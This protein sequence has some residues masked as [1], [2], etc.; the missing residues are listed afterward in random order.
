MNSEAQAMSASRPWKSDFEPLDGV[1]D[2]RP[3][4]HDATY[5]S[6]LFVDATREIG[7]A[8]LL[9]SDPRPTFVLDLSP[10]GKTLARYPDLVYCSLSMSKD[11]GLVDI[12]KSTFR[13]VENSTRTETVRSRF[14]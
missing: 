5:L 7:I 13:S 14:C 12:I 11:W 1:N 2:S 4:S 3:Q 9:D 10:D 6:Q 8:E